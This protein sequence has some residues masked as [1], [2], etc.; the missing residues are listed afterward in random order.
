[1]DTIKPCRN[2]NNRCID[3]L[4]THPE[5]ICRP[6]LK[7]LSRTICMYCQKDFHQVQALSNCEKSICWKCEASQK[8]HGEPLPCHFC[9]QKA[10]FGQAICR[11]CQ[12]DSEKYG[13]PIECDSCRKKCAFLKPSDLKQKVGGKNLCYLC[14]RSYKLM[15]HRNKKQNQHNK[16]PT[17]AIDITWS[18]AKR[19]F[20]ETIKDDDDPPHKRQ[21]LSPNDGATSVNPMCFGCKSMK[22]TFDEYKAQMQC[23]LGETAKRVDDYQRMADKAK[24]KA[25]QYRREKLSAVERIGELNGELEKEQR[26]YHRDVSV[27][28]EY[29]ETKNKRLRSQLTAQ[30]GLHETPSRVKQLEKNNESLKRNKKELEKVQKVRSNEEKEWKI[31]Y[32]KMNELAKEN[33]DKL[34]REIH[35]ANTRYNTY[36]SFITIPLT[37]TFSLCFTIE[38]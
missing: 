16:S 27:K 30:I 21:K 13:T 5:Q 11:H 7:V 18:S 36:S 6:C 25:D 35:A 37:I 10:A 3:S 33:E 15:Q 31:S 29:S 17:N 24:R 32:D 2:C 22:H 28:R 19:S 38:K 4:R 20:D 26:K 34:T 9:C 1:M 14:T 8:E 23:K 12:K